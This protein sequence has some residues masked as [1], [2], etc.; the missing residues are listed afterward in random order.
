MQVAQNEGKT[1]MGRVNQYPQAARIRLQRVEKPL[2]DVEHA[3]NKVLASLPQVPELGW[4]NCIPKDPGRRL[5]E[6]LDGIKKYDLLEHVAH[7][8]RRIEE[9]IR[10]YI[11]GKLPVWLRA[12]K[13]AYNAIKKVQYALRIVATA[14]FLKSLIEE[15]IALANHYCNEGLL[16]IGFAESNL[17]P[18]GLQTQ[19]EQELVR[20]WQKARADLLSQITQNTAS[21]DCII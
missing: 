17:T 14:F 10:Q 2:I 6:H 3:A 20:V 12:P 5:K 1:T 8:K 19:A 4:H 9:N 15:E 11:D 7:A 13:Y 16:L 21:L 18:A